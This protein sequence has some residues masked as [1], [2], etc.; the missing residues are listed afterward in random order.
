MDWRRQSDGAATDWASCDDGFAP[1]GCGGSDD[2][3]AAVAVVVAAVA[4]GDAV[5]A[6]AGAAAVVGDDRQLRRPNWAMTWR[7]S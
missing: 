2:S 1:A 3:V 6:A 5:A 4:V 7:R